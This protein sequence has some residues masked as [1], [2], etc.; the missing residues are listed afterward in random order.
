MQKRRGVISSVLLV[1]CLWVG[2]SMVLAEQDMVRFGS[3]NWPGVTVKTEVVS[4]VLQALG[5]ETE[6]NQLQVPAIFKALSMDQL[7][8]FMGCWLPTMDN[9]VKPYLSKNEIV[10][11]ATNLEK[12]EYR[13]AVPAYVW[14][15]GVTSM[16]DLDRAE[17]RDR[18]DR[19]GDGTPEI[20]GIEPGNDGNKL[21]IDAIEADTYGLGDWDMIPSSTAGMLSQVKKAAKDDEWIV[22]LGWEPHWM[23]LEWELK[24]LDDPERIWGEPGATHVDTATRSG[25]N[26]ASPNLATFLRQVVIE[27]DWQSKWIMGYTYEGNEPEDVARVWIENNLDKV[28]EWLQ[29][30]R[31]QDGSRDGMTALKAAFAN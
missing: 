9:Y 18:F 10:L 5:Y 29:G 8:V 1:L 6:I 26:E 25:L 3:V 2:P 17:F 27:A 16:A 13:N 20:Y 22:F 24:Y 30:V 31:T 4:Q 19:N 7:D 21:I 23:N 15:A 11:L 28:A 14:E 12:T